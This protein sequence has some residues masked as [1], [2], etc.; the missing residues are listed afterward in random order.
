[1]NFACEK[2]FGSHEEMFANA[3]EVASAAPPGAGVAMLP[4]FAHFEYSLRE[5]LWPGRAKPKLTKQYF[6]Q[7]GVQDEIDWCV[8]K[9]LATGR[10]AHA[11]SMQ[12]RNWQALAYCLGGR[13]DAAREV[14]AEI[15][16]LVG[17]VSQW[18]I[19]GVED[20]AET[21]VHWRQ[22]AYGERSRGP[23]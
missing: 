2:W 19:F 8:D 18:S 15:G 11:R 20:A 12:L 1:M 7:K 16:P 23:L 6:G 22:W 3:R 13:T 21:F 17:D 5:H 9:W 14:F 10:P 4:V